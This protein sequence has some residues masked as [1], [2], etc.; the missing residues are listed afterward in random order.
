M[1]QKKQSAC[2]DY[3]HCFSATKISPQLE[4]A[5]SLFLYRFVR[6][7]WCHFTSQCSTFS[8]TGAIGVHEDPVRARRAGRPRKWKYAGRAKCFRE[9]LVHVFDHHVDDGACWQHITTYIQT[10]L[11]C[12]S[13][14]L[15]DMYYCCARILFDFAAAFTP[16]KVNVKCSTS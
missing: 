16:P 11:R 12:C 4:G 8:S 2:I 13:L 5:W 15:L 7:P 9:P 3:P 6:K 14:C 10:L 1:L